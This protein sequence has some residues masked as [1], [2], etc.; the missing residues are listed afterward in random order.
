MAQYVKSL[1][2]KAD[3]LNLMSRTCIVEGVELLQVVH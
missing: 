2:A 3:N 1:A